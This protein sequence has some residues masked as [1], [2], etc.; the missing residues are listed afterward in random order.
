[1]VANLAYDRYWA[2]KTG[3]QPTPAAA[4]VV[5][6]VVAVAGLAAAVAA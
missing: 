6:A 5:A 2:D 1:M 3:K 4:G